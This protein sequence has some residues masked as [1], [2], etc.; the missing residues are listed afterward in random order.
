[1]SANDI[2]NSNPNLYTL[3]CLPIQSP[4][5]WSSTYHKEK[6]KAE[7]ELEEL[8]AQ[9]GPVKY[10]PDQI[11]QLEESLK[12]YNT[13]LETLLLSIIT[14][15]GYEIAAGTSL[16]IGLAA[17]LQAFITY[18]NE[19]LADQ[20]INLEQKSKTELQEIISFLTH[21]E[22]K[23]QA[24][25]A[26]FRKFT[27]ADNDAYAIV[28]DLSAEQSVN[29]Q[30][31]LK[32]FV[33][34]I[35]DALTVLSTAG[36]IG[37]A[38]KDLFILHI[39]VAADLVTKAATDKHA[40]PRPVTVHSI[41]VPARKEFKGNFSIEPLHL[42]PAT[43]S[44]AKS[45][46]WTPLTRTTTLIAFRTRIAQEKEEIRAQGGPVRFSHA[47]IEAL[48]KALPRYSGKIELVVSPTTA[49]PA[50]LLAQASPFLDD[51]NDDVMV[52]NN[53]LKHLSDSL[54]AEHHSEEI[55]ALQEFLNAVSETFKQAQ[56][57]KK[58]ISRTL[59]DPSTYAIQEPK[60]RKHDAEISL[61]SLEQELNN[62]L[63]GLCGQIIG[64]KAAAIIS[65]ELA[66]ACNL[67][68]RAHSSNVTT[69]RKLTD[70]KVKTSALSLLNV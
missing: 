31:P 37:S 59:I 42:K 14:E 57:T 48:K 5:I 40:V 60:G 34:T 49:D 26:L 64:T 70:V 6:A 9:G 27:Q 53:M 69:L 38:Y 39:Q 51:I 33:T 28:K 22:L 67:L 50:P 7:R 63:T 52:I 23:I 20:S 10:T 25:I 58:F 30:K 41:P 19:T 11:K 62:A 3:G 61:T 44:K 66:A 24:L 56:E 18:L 13:K 65:K 36:L 68:L 54:D 15:A 29:V 46:R 12:R 47:D 8:R 55:D 17:D 2:D 16:L 1:M 45:K 4:V 21:G 43:V 32:E 35:K